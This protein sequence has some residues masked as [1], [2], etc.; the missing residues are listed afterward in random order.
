MHLH[1]VVPALGKQR[2]DRAV[3]EAAGEN[4]FFRRTAFAFEVAAGKPAGRSGLLA[5]IHGQREEVLA[6]LGLDGRNG[7]DDDDG[8]AELNGDGTVGLFGKFASFNNELFVPER[9][10]DFM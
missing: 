1:F 9:G 7:G 2:T 5:V 3:G 4:F 8:F 10:G 6:F